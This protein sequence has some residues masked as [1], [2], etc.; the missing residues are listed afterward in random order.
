MAL[1][2]LDKE[3][4]AVAVAVGVR[5]NATEEMGFHGLGLESRKNGCR[6]RSKAAYE[7]LASLGASLAV[8][9]T[10]NIAK[11]MPSAR[12]LGVTQAD[13]D[14]VAALTETMRTRAM[15]LGQARFEESGA[16]SSQTARDCASTPATCC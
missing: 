12:A 9:C 6:C 8:N 13:L 7:E 5:T 3:R 11:H 1:T 16:H 2:A 14:E 10:E 4:V 15:N